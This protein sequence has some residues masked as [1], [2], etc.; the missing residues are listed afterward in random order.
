MAAISMQL[1][2][3]IATTNRF[4]I[5]AMGRSHSAETSLAGGMIEASSNPWRSR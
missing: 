4:R 3:A 1:V 2:R 5:A